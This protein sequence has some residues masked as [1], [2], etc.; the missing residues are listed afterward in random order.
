ML[1]AIL[2]TV[3][4]LT[5]QLLKIPDPSDFVTR[6]TADVAV[7]Y[8][9]LAVACLL[10]SEHR[11]ARWNWT[12]GCGAFLVHVAIAFDRVHGWRH[13]AAFDHVQDVSGYGPG[14]FVSYA[15]TLFWLADVLWWWLNEDHY[16]RRPNWLNGMLHFFMAF[17]VF[18]GTVVYEKGFIRW[19][20]IGMF[21]VL[22]A[23]ALRRFRRGRNVSGFHSPT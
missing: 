11:L 8:W 19:A 13:E 20:G 6:R 5:P 17:I 4:L 22:V 3:A 7:A 10:M 2:L 18:N 16:E 23:L 21:A 1:W 15:F 9:A 12:L 14:I